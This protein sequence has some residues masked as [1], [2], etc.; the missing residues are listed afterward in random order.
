MPK[1]GNIST[2][3]AEITSAHTETGL[4]PRTAM[5]PPMSGA[6]KMTDIPLSP[7]TIPACAED[8]VV[9]S[10]SHGIATCTA[11]LPADPNKADIPRSML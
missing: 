9:S 1:I 3:I 10:T 6:V 8:P 5:S 7:R 2:E 11:E 4:A